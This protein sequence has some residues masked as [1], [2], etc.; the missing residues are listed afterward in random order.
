MCPL[1]RLTKDS[2]IPKLFWGFPS[3][4]SGKESTANAGDSRDMGLIPGSGRSSG[5][6]NGK[7]LHSS[8]LA[9]EI[10]WTEEL[11]GYSPWGYKES[12]MTER[13]CTHT[14]THTLLPHYPLQKNFDL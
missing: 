1:Y 11:E 8:I 3:G 6:E 10:P 14:H 4:V 5:E 2:S 7:P 13:V 12:D 9:W